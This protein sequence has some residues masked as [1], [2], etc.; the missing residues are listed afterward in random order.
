[1]ATSKKYAFGLEKNVAAALTYLLAWLT[2]VIFF[3]V[4][5]DPDIRF[6]AVQ[7]IIFF[8]GL[9]ILGMVPVL[10]WLL[11]P[12]LFLIGL[13]GWIVLLV[14]AYQGEKFKLPVVGNLALK[15]SRH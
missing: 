10:G 8:G 12:F 6:H 1:M 14:K 9:T 2:G 5:K 15:F 4:E 11:S 13:I 3:L 7:S